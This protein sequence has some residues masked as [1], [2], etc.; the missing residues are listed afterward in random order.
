MISK[1]HN[2]ANWRIEKN[3]NLQSPSLL[4]RVS[5]DLAQTSRGEEDMARVNV[6]SGRL[7]E[8]LVVVMNDEVFGLQVSCLME[9][10]KAVAGECILI[11]DILLL[12]EYYFSASAVEGDEV[13]V[14]VC[15][16]VASGIIQSPKIACQQPISLL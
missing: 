16:P 10:V 8:L 15:K 5:E 2:K 7:L 13:C 3:S 6:V 1:A 4:G 12:S 14:Y 11:P 9:N